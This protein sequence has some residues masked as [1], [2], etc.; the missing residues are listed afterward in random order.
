[1][2]IKG[3]VKVA[4]LINLPSAPMTGNRFHIEKTTYRAAK[5]AIRAIFL[6]DENCD[7]EITGTLRK[8][9]FFKHQPSNK[10]QFHRVP[11]NKS[12][13]FEMNKSF[14][15][16]SFVHLTRAKFLIIATGI[17]SVPSPMTNS[18]ADAISSATA[19]FF[20]FSV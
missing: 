1:M 5:Q 7:L 4:A 15:D 2:P 9:L 8:D 12:S 17:A 13:C 18:A 16:D 19:E 6:V 10:E 14:I 20:T 3:A 11:L